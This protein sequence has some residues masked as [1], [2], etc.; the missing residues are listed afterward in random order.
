MRSAADPRLS[1]IDEGLT[2][3]RNAPIY[4]YYY[5]PS[6]PSWVLDEKLCLRLRFS[7]LYWNSLIKFLISDLP[8]LPTYIF[9]FTSELFHNL[10]HQET[11]DQTLL[12]HHLSS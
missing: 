4:L 9:S 8:P 11:S 2:L 12:K 5:Y 10:H 3:S 7:S 1:M 6:P